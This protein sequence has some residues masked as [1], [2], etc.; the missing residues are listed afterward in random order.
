MSISFKTTCSYQVGNSY[1]HS[2][3]SRE[4]QQQSPSEG[5]RVK[6]LY[7]CRRPGR[8][9]QAHPAQRRSGR[10]TASFTL[11]NPHRAERTDN[12][13]SGSEDIGGFTTQEIN[14]VLVQDRQELYG[15]VK[16]AEDLEAPRE[17][18]RSQLD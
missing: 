13:A 2:F 6:L 11:T 12:K 4:G 1:H 5:N 16:V 15:F 8:S 14:K 18:L 7:A 17:L 10:P 9:S 3:G